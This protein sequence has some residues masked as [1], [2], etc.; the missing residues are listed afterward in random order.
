[1]QSTSTV[2]VCVCLYVCVYVYVLLL[3]S[4]FLFAKL[5]PSSRKGADPIS[6]GRGNGQMQ[7]SCPFSASQVE[8]HNVRSQVST[9]AVPRLG[10]GAWHYARH[11]L[12]SSK[13]APGPWRETPLEIARDLL[14][15]ISNYD[16]SHFSESTEV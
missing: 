13:S 2:C 16:S 9:A 14:E 7:I 4:K 6:P 5:R 8:R 10:R 11:K 15:N 3:A 1:M 12:C